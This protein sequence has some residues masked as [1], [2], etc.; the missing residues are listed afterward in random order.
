[1]RGRLHLVKGSEQDFDAKAPKEEER[2]QYP[3]PDE[4][5]E[6]SCE[7]D[8]TRPAKPT[9]SHDRRRAS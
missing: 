2:F 6:V 9:L 3:G 5:W 7:P 1:M 4:P 8:R